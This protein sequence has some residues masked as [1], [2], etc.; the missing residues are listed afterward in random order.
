MLKRSEAGQSSSVPRMSRRE[1]STYRPGSTGHRPSDD[2]GRQ[3]LQPRHDAVGHGAP[4]L[5]EGLRL[6]V[7]VAR[8]APRS[9]RP[10]S[11]RGGA[12]TGLVLGLQLEDRPWK[13]LESIVEASD[14]LPLRP[15]FLIAGRENRDRGLF[16]PRT[17]SAKQS[18]VGGRH[19]ELSLLRH[20]GS[21]Q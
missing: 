11:F 14:P 18:E 6:A 8:G 3:A 1:S 7:Y 17:W 21:H 12:A 16:V 4:H 2:C 5:S 20:G 15:L 9:C 13:T 19:G 10:K